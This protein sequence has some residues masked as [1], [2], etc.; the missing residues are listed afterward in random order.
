MAC[1]LGQ[2][3]A[4]AYQVVIRDR[5]GPQVAQVNFTQLDWDRRLD[6]VSEAVVQIPASECKRIGAVQPWR[7]ELSI[8]RDN[9]EQWVGPVRVPI[10]CVSGITIKATDV[11]GWLQ[12]RIIHALHDW[13]GMDVGSVQMAIELIQDGYAPDDP[14]VL[15]FLTGLGV[16]DIGGRTYL[17]NSAYVIDALVDLAKG[18]L[19][20]TTIGR[21]V[22]VMPEGH[23]LGKTAML[24]CE[25]FQTDLCRSSDGD[26]YASRAVV[27]GVGVTGEAG[28]KDDY[29]GLVEVLKDDQAIGR[30]ATADANAAGLLSGR[31]RVPDLIQPPAGAGLSPDAPVC[32]SELVP[33]VT[34]PVAI[35]CTCRGITQDQRLT[36]LKVSVSAEGETVAPILAPL[37]FS[38]YDVN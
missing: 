21:R 6:D 8:S 24:T 5:F 16:G 22:I 34:V 26:A 20:F 9:Q 10:D 11:L 18:S 29:Y 32:L 28:G 17:A 30:Q 33:G 36:G 1:R 27:T 3:T 25:H 4:D 15:Q 13:A 2:C 37:G 14:N 23:V 38:S 7:H 19:D 35:N 31:N 12:R